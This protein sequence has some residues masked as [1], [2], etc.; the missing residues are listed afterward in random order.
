MHPPR[1]PL[2]R[3]AEIPVFYTNKNDGYCYFN[4]DINQPIYRKGEQWYTFD[5]EMYNIRRNGLFS[6]RPNNPQVGFAY[7]CTDKQTSE[8]STN[9]IMIYHKGDN[10]WVDALGRVIS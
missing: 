5:G 1:L 6:Q 9:G 2:A 4:T 3:P 10:V 7:F 8:G